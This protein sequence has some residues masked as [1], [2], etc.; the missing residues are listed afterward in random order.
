MGRTLLLLFLGQA[1]SFNLAITSFTVSLITNQG[2]DAPLTVSFFSYVAL[3]LVYGSIM[4]YRRQ[5]LLVPWYW[6]VLLGFVDV[7]GNYLV[8]KAYEYTSITSVTI[9]DCWTIAWVIILTWLVLGTR[10][11]LWQLFGAGV[12]LGGLALVVLSDTK[13]DVGGGSKPLFG[14]TLV[15]AGTVFLSMSNVGMEFCVK[16]KD[17]VEVL[18]MIGIFGMLVSASGMATV[19]RRSL[20][21]INWSSQLVLAYVGCTIASFMFDT[22]GPFV[23]KMSGATLFNLSLLTSD[24]WA[25]VIRIF[26]YKQQ[27]KWLYYPAYAL[28]AL[29]ILI[30]SKAEKDHDSG[31]EIEDAKTNPEYSLLEGGNTNSH[32]E[33]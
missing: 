30:Y 14:E 12:C 25:V 11:S 3:A 15:I 17:R 20:E 28:V 13:P 10:Y 24:M 31:Q 29:G 18:T 4:L 1:V 32:Q 5:K 2:V 8:A 26:I 7:Q 21:S 9:L 16:R 23:L 19:E 27:V 6:Y 33:I 22:L